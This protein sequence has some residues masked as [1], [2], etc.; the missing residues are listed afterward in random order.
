MVDLKETLK[1]RGAQYGE[2]KSHAEISQ[3]LNKG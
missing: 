3:E 2:F 1:E